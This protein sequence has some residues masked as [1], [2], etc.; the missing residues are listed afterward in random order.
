MRRASLLTIL[1]VVNLASV[2]IGTR[3]S[4]TAGA[5]T[6]AATS[7]RAAPSVEILYSA[8][9]PAAALP[10]GSALNF[11]VWHATIDPGVQ[12]SVPAAYVACCPGPVVLHVLSGELAIRVDGS[13]RVARAGSPGTPA[14]VEELTEDTER[15][16][17]PGESA[18][19]R[20]E[21][22]ASYTNP[23]SIPVHLV[24]GGLLGGYAPAPVENYVV[25][26]FTE[27]FPVPPLPAG[28]V[29][30]ELVRVTLAPGDP[31]PAPPAGSLRLGLKES[32][33]GILA[34]ELDVSLV[35]TVREPIVV[36][37]LAL[38]PRSVA[39]TLAP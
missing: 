21:L 17:R 33:G 37:V 16:L 13:L 32:G 3:S 2:F 27:I 12:V 31:L 18:A 26:E 19:Y 38:Y 4:A 24:G 10:T 15:T 39:S 1:L 34:K 30:M 8:N 7:G 25:S 29:T 11:I 6:A 23:G 9:Y 20:F 14:P 5:Q 35:N 36:D 22:P 28:P